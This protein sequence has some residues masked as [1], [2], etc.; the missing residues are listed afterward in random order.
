MHD[1]KRRLVNGGIKP[2]EK[3]HSVREMAGEFGVTPNT[4]QRAFS[5][6]E[7]EALI[8]TERTSG[9]YATDDEEKL[10]TLR[11]ELSFSAVKEYLKTMYALGF[12]HQEAKDAVLNAEMIN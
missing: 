4:L 2:G 7:R 5:E 9:R 3:I 11:R 12:S 8:R 10:N 6:L 1:F